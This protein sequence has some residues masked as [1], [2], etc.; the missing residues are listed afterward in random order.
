MLAVACGEWPEQREVKRA[1]RAGGGGTP[2]AVLEVAERRAGSVG[3]ANK[4]QR[5]LIAFRGIVA[6]EL[7]TT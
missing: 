4:L 6:G 1:A 5:A 7:P 3:L 2:A